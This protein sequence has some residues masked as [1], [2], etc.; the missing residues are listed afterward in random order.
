MVALTGI[1][2]VKC[3]F[4][5]CYTQLTRCFLVFDGSVEFEPSSRVNAGC[6]RP[7]T[8]FSGREAML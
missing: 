6:D 1:E 5:G 3:R 4:G 7:V 2:W 8:P